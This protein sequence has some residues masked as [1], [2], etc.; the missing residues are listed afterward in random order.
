MQFE[1]CT[2]TPPP[3]FFLEVEWLRTNRVFFLLELHVRSDD[4]VLFSCFLL[5]DTRQK[6]RSTRS[7]PLP[8]LGLRWCFLPLYKTKDFLDRFSIFLIHSLLFSNSWLFYFGGELFSFII[9]SLHIFLCSHRDLFC[10]LNNLSFL[11]NR[12]SSFTDVI[13]FLP[14]GTRVLFGSSFLCYL[15]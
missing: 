12:T 13:S 2:S 7:S 14:K 10:F 8:V 6:T 1:N 5:Q 4:L 3:F 11:K 9:Q 15:Q